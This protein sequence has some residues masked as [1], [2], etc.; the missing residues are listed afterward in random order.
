[1]LDKVTEIVA[2]MIG[3]FHIST[4][5][6]RMRDAYSEIHARRLA[7]AQ[8]KA[9]LGQSSTFKA[10]YQLEDFTPRGGYQDAPP[11]GPQ[12][13]SYPFLVP[14]PQVLPF[15]Y[16]LPS[17]ET[18]RHELTGQPAH[19][20]HTRELT[21][22]PPGAVV[23]IT[24][25]ANFMTDNDLLRFSGSDRVFTDPS[26]YDVQ[27]QS[28]AGLAAKLMPILPTSALPAL[29][30]SVHAPALALHAAIAEIS[31][32]KATFATELHIVKGPDALGIHVNGAVVSEAP[33]LDDLMP[34][35]MQAQK[36]QADTAAA[37][38]PDSPPDWA[39][40]P[41][42]GLNAAAVA[43]GDIPNLPENAPAHEVITGAN[44]LV[45]Q[46][47]IITA[48]LDAPVIVVK[49][50]V[51]NLNVIS[52]INVLIEHPSFGAG[53][54]SSAPVTTSASYNSAQIS[55][56]SSRS[57]NDAPSQD[58]GP[59]ALPSNWVVTR[60]TGDLLTVNHVHQ[61]SFLTDHDRADIGF[62]T[63]KTFVDLG[64]N[65]LVNLTNILEIGFGYDLVIIGGNMISINQ[66]EQINVLLDSDVISLD[67][68]PQTSVSAGDNLVFN[69]ASISITGIDSYHG[70][71]APFA[72]ATDQLARGED[73]DKDTAHDS[74][75]EGT[76]ILRVLYI[77]GDATTINLV[78]QT[79]ILG[80]SDQV[81]LA[82]DAM[83]QSLSGQ[84]AL[85]SGSNAAINLASI[86]QFGVDS[87]V[88][89]G[90]TVYD[91][92]LIYQA[93]FID[94]DANPLGVALQPLASEAV[95]FLADDMLTQEAPQDAGIHPT[96]IDA[97]HTPD[98]MQ[99][100]LA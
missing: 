20:Y 85:T 87:D 61:Y 25:Q 21:L 33:S 46:T 86:A 70:M 63:V 88:L 40:D 55:L 64:D 10:P 18:L 98:V 22:T 58:S 4:E 12:I 82:H 5:E 54:Q 62:H 52:Q 90:G 13:A 71:K 84:V 1:M 16:T 2:H 6:D 19:Q 7:D 95:A 14:L 31:P 50:D 81:H 30:V 42:S 77:S 48:W 17:P 66:I 29:G 11:P 49:G 27:L 35:F 75:F 56:T 41:F 43:Q 57:P 78:Q 38:D 59:G 51:I 92:A 44:L 60:I 15:W 72:K 68:I 8:S 23:T 24:Y 37:T 99:S 83:S 53:M 47:S 26:H 80:D 93:G 73:I 100:M 39:P 96:H 76:D 91:D 97:T 3:I 9:L 89:V 65:H 28:Y 94:T 34:A 79:N 74:I 32:T 69:G 36:A 45:N 67:G